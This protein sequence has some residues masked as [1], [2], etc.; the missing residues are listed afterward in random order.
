MLLRFGQSLAHSIGEGEAIKIIDG[1]IKKVT[2]LGAQ[3]TCGRIGLREKAWKWGSGRVGPS[4]ILSRRSEQ[5][6]NCN[7]LGR[8]NHFNFFLLSFVG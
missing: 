3:G 1:S 7:V 8:L 5:V 6:N 2:V 4:Y